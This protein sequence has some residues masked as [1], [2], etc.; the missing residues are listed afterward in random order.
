MVHKAQVEVPRA[1]WDP[2]LRYIRPKLR[3][4]RPKLRYIGYMRP[5]LRYIGPKLRYIRPK[6]EQA[7][8]SRYLRA[9]STW[10][11]EKA[12]FG[13]GPWSKNAAKPTLLRGPGRKST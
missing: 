10:R 6:L 7:R 1:V 11:P 8:I 5:K 9:L 12:R 4:I 13:R 3:Y 2:M